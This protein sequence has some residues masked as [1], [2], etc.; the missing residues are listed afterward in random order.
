MATIDDL[1]AALQSP[2]GENSKLKN[3]FNTWRRIGNR[4]DFAE[5]GMN[6]GELDEFLKEWIADNPYLSIG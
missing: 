4:D 6:R 5:L 1:L 3:D 2:E